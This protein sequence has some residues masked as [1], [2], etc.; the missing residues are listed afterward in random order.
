[1]DMPLTAPA[2]ETSRLE[3]GTVVA[4]SAS[5]HRGPRHVGIVTDRVD[6][7]GLPLVVHAS[8]QRGRVVEEPWLGFTEGRQAQVLGT[9]PSPAATLARARSRIRQATGPNTEDCEH[10]VAW[11]RGDSSPQVTW[12]SVLAVA[13][14]MV[15]AGALLLALDPPELGASRTASAR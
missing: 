12:G 9:D 5:H 6:E 15:V 13:I 10:F 7:Y 2:P 11:A 4:V 14:V 3:P 8:H 1:M